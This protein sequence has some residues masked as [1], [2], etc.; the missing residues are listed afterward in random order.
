MPGRFGRTDSVLQSHSGQPLATARQRHAL[1]RLWRFLWPCLKPHRGRFVLI[2]ALTLIASALAALQPWPLKLVA[3]H[4]LGRQPLPGLLAAVFDVIRLQPTPLRLLAVATFGGLALFALHSIVEL[5]LTSTWTFAGRRMVHDLAEALFARLQ[6][7]SLL[8]HSRHPVGDIMSRITGDSW[9]VYQFVDTILFA[10]GHALLTMGLMV[11]LMAGLD[12]GLT[13][14]ALA[15]APLMVGASFLIGKPLHLAARLKR[16][17]EGRIQS[18]LQQTLTGIPVVQAFVQED[19][20]QER[21]RQFADDAV[22]AQQRSAVLGSINSL[23]SGFVATIGAGA[24]L[25]FGA[26]HVLDGS[27]TIGS[28]LVFFVYLTALH[29]QIKTFA[30]IHTGWRSV[31][32]SLERVL[33]MLESEPEVTEPDGAPALPR[34][35]GHIAFENVTFGY[36]SDRPVLRDVSFEAQPGQTVAIVGP[37][38]VGKSTL[39]ALIPRFFDPWHGKVRIDAHDVRRLQ[40]QSLRQ[41]IAV[42]LQEPFLFPLSIAQNIAY[43]RPDA[44]RSQIAAA[45]RDANAHLFIERLPLAYDTIIG[46]RGATL[47]G[48]ERQRLAIARALLRDAPILILDEPTSALDAGTESLL[49]EAL[50]RLMTGRTTLLIAHRL[51]TI[52]RADRILVLQDGRITEG[53]THSE[54]LV[55]GKF[56]AHLHE[57][58][59]RAHTPEPA[60]TR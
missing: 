19:R 30:G 57:I 43:G 34:P 8:F 18:H 59:F 54:L 24:I 6:R 38:G 49:L 45:A 41:Q 22:R 55:R 36:E 25:W 35:H 12:P 1:T 20:E 2:T 48:G 23:G 42:V 47:S 16:E 39:A 27:L 33:E 44:S 17:I 32:A 46:E 3:D 15:V 21:F 28:L 31:S 60:V 7:R 5:V 11:L 40:L 56:Y 26:R 51:S 10:P 50:G 9:C 53:G 14:L 37:T 29:A 58:Q 4:V 52:R 13:L